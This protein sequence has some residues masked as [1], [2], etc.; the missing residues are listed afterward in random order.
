MAAAETCPGQS[1]P[2]VTTSRAT[3]EPTDRRHRRTLR[4]RQAIESA[5]LR[6]FSERGFDATTVQQIAEA[7]EIAPRTFFRHFPSK[8]AVLFGDRHRE[9]E[10][11]RHVLVTRP[12]G[13]HPLRSIVAAMLDTAEFIEADREQHLMR[14]RLL[15]SLEAQADYELLLL[16]QRWVQDLTDLVAERL[17]TTVGDPRAGAW[18]MTLGS[19]FG[20]A[21][22]AWLVRSDGTPLRDIFNQLLADTGDALAEAVRPD[23]T[24]QCD[25]E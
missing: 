6:L 24:A 5:A 7:A 4:T 12:T 11:L 19:C 23:S 2:D 16:R 22:H 18:A 1:D 14:A 13:E 15:T 10:Q 9:T 21:M 3:T 8:E 25:T 17:G 20:S